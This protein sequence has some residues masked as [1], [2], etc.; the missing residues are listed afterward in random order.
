MSKLSKITVVAILGVICAFTILFGLFIANIF[1][2]GFGAGTGDYV[3][4]L[5][6]KYQVQHAAASSELGYT[7]IENIVDSRVVVGNELNGI[8]WDENFICAR[9]KIN[10]KEQYWLIDLNKDNIYGPFTEDEFN[11]K[12]EELG[13]NKDLKL[14]KPEKYR[15]LEREQFK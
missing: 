6:D 13:V 8:A 5:S 11:I 9:Q 4:N 7:K 14:K 12:K 3:Y 10:E 15:N 2:G 1:T